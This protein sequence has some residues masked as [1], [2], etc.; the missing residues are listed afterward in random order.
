M[1]DVHTTELVDEETDARR[2][3]LEARVKARFEKEK[4]RLEEEK[5][6]DKNISQETQNEL[7][8]QMQ[9]L[10]K[11]NGTTLHKGAG[12]NKTQ[13]TRQKDRETNEDILSKLNEIG[14]AKKR[15]SDEKK[16]RELKNEKQE[17]VK[18]EEHEQKKLK[19]KFWSKSPKYKTDESF[20]LTIKLMVYHQM[21]RK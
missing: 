7:L 20:S 17:R 11:K 10:R 3:A 4:K 1:A 13:I 8:Q 6:L 2:S 15:N 19:R 9:E 5:T 21:V 14:D 18:M 12:N 16:L